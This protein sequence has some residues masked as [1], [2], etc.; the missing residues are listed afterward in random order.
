MTYN[1]C[2]KNQFYSTD[3]IHQVSYIPLSKPINIQMYQIISFVL[4]LIAHINLDIAVIKISA[5]LI[6]TYKVRCACQCEDL[7]TEFCLHVRLTN[8]LKILVFYHSLRD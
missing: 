7:I 6:H 8:L 1:F 2:C 5:V 4:D 3:Y